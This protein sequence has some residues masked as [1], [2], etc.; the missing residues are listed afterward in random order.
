[1]T[2]HLLETVSRRP[3]PGALIEFS[4]GT[5]RTDSSGSFQI[6]AS[7]AAIPLTVTAGGHVTR[8]S[9]LGPSAASAPGPTLDVIETGDWVVVDADRGC[10]EVRKADGDS[11]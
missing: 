1:M 9:S 8:R 4:T 11:R 7:G 2:G 6:P 5:A 3:V 10:V